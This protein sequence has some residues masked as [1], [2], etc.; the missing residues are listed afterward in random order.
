MADV[1]RLPGVPVDL[2]A[3]QYRINCATSC[4]CVAFAPITASARFTLPRRSRVTDPV[5]A[6]SRQKNGSMVTYT[7]RAA[8]DILRPSYR[9]GDSRVV[10]YPFPPFTVVSAALP[11]SSTMPQQAPGAT[12]VG[13]PRTRLG[14]A[15]VRHSVRLTSPRTIQSG[16][17]LTT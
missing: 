9:R 10:S 16:C 8:H 1:E 7:S 2:P 5:K 17:F 14:D 13:Q 11:P 3:G 4:S 15:Q 6:G 12:P